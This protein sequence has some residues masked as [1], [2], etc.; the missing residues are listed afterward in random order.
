MKNKFFFLLFCI[1]FLF[2]QHHS[3]ALSVKEDLSN[4]Y[5]LKNHKFTLG[6]PAGIFSE[7][8]KVYFRKYKKELD[9]PENLN[10]ISSIYF[11]N[12]K[13]SE[14][15]RLDQPIWLSLKYNSDSNYKKS[16]YFYNGAIDAWEKI[17]SI[18]KQKKDRVRADWYFPYS[19]VAVFEDPSQI[20]GPV[21][22]S[23]YTDFDDYIDAVSAISIDEDSGKILYQKNIDEIRSIASLTKVM[24]ALIFLETETP[25]DKVITYNSAN[26]REGARLYVY[27]GET[28][29][30]QDII[31]TMLVGSANNCALTLADSTG[32]ARE[33]FVARMNEKADELD[34]DN[35][36]FDDPSGLEVGNVSTAY[37]YARLMQVALDEY[38]ILQASTTQNYSFY[39]INTNNFHSINNTNLVL[40]WD[41]YLTGGKTGYLDE[42]LY[43]LMIK[44]KE[45]DHEVI[46]VLLGNPNSYDR[47]IET[48]NLTKWAF[49]NY[50]WE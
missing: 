26:D 48:Y 9:L 11:Y 5:I 45:D 43:C 1:L 22:A 38:E 14:Q 31:Y 7:E 2:P 37:D 41:L 4:G 24:T 21:M 33:D 19:I 12:I 17:D 46:T 27:D 40:D 49:A 8:A 13:I 35:T 34:L 20:N 23:D 3:F 15:E 50:S 36:H 42:A 39:T 44:A 30:V 6:I 47:F 29:T 16:L 32:L 10:L 25:M 18:D 28:M